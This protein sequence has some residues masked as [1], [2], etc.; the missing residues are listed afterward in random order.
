MFMRSFRQPSLIFLVN[1][2]ILLGFST[3]GKAD[4]IQPPEQFPIPP[5]GNYLNSL[6]SDANGHAVVLVGDQAGIQSTD[7]WYF[8]NGTWTPTTLISAGPNIGNVAV[9]MEPSGTA[10]ALVHDGSNN[11]LL[12]FYFNGTSWSPPPTNPLDTFAFS[13]ASMAVTMNAPGQGLA[14]WTD[15]IDVKAA[16]FSGSNWGPVTILGTGQLAVSVAFSAKGSAVVGWQDGINVKVSNFINGSWQGPVILDPSGAFVTINSVISNLQTVG[17]DALGNALALWIDSSGNIVFK[18]FNG[19]TWSPLPTIV[20][21]GSNNS[22]PSLAMAPIGTAVAVWVDAAGNGLSSSYD[23]T[24]WSS[25]IQF[26]TDKVNSN[27]NPAVST[28]CKGNALI[29]WP[30]VVL[31]VVSVR[32][33]R[34]GQF[35]EQ[36]I[37]SISPPSSELFSVY[38]S[39]LFNGR[40]FAS[41]L[42]DT[43]ETFFVNV[44]SLKI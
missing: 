33:S 35:G 16:F 30:T 25:P 19:S 27:G 23:R 3:Q 28:N 40:G 31:S 22:V 41:W 29:V 1:I 37:I 18:K 42:S 26:S 20:G 17:M 12:T 32:L 39:L 15:G 6:A 13:P 2:F 7:A 24:T 10:L 4:W 21:S 5:D 36:E 8:S 43:S 11:Q 14:A 44:F 9:A 34:E 38:S